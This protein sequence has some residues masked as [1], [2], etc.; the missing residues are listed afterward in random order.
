MHRLFIGL[1]VLFLCGCESSGTSTGTGSVIGNGLTD[2]QLF[3][4]NQKMAIE[5]FYPRTW[6]LTAS[7][8]ESIV[9]LVNTDASSSGA[10]SSVLFFQVTDDLAGRQFNSPNELLPYLQTLYPGRQWTA[11]SLLWGQVGYLTHRHS[12]GRAWGEHVLLTS[13]RKVLRITFEVTMS[14]ED[15]NT[16]QRILD[17][18]TTRN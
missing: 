16:I 5:F 13:D 4:R 6:T 3:Y 15:Y 2:N 9:R 7:S 12:G 1:F 14:L 17:S 18:L 10:D 11:T 8:D